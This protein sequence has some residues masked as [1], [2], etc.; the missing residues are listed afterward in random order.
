MPHLACS[1]NRLATSYLHACGCYLAL[2]KIEGGEEVEKRRREGTK[3]PEGLFDSKTKFR[4]APYSSFD[5]QTNL[6]ESTRLL[7]S[8]EIESRITMQ[9]GARL[10]QVKTFVVRLLSATCPWS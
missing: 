1:L 10:I 9:D 5:T 3:E 7:D 4:L 6:I 2:E 8:I